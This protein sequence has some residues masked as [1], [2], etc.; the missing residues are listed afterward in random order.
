MEEDE[1]A[2]AEK[3]KEDKNGAAGGNNS[4]NIDGEGGKDKKDGEL[5]SGEDGSQS[6]SS[7][8]MDTPNPFR[9]PGDAE[10]FWHR[11]LNMVDQ[12]GMEDE[13]K[14]EDN[15]NATEKPDES[16]KDGAFEFA[17]QEQDN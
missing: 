14:D 15:V 10:K 5:Q 13:D 12:S 6:K 4:E 1:N 16:N 3:E 7:S 2:H 17:S 9:D 8:T 11:K